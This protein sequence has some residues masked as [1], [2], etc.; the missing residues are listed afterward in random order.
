MLPSPNVKMLLFSA[1]KPITLK[2]CYIVFVYLN[3]GGIVAGTG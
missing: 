1:V 3:T 2:K